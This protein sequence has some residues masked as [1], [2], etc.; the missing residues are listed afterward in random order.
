MQEIEVVV[1]K[2]ELSSS[3]SNQFRNVL[4]FLY[5]LSLIAE[6]TTFHTKKRD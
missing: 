6:M 3:Q 5:D 2:N 4:L 1:S